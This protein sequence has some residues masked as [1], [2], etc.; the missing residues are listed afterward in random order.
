MRNILSITDYPISDKKPLDSLPN[1]QQKTT[2]SYGNYDLTVL[3]AQGSLSGILIISC[4]V[5]FPKISVRCL[6]GS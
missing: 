2:N 6:P 5:E 1:I 4:G 3:L